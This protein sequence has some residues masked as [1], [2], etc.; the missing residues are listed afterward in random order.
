MISYEEVLKMKA[1]EEA[2][3]LIAR[4]IMEWKKVKYRG[5]FDWQDKD[6]DNVYSVKGWNPSK[7]TE[8]AIEAL[9]TRY[10][11]TIE[12]DHSGNY[13]VKTW[14]NEYAGARAAVAETLALAACRSLLL[15]EA[16][17]E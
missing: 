14:V 6:G 11:Y 10:E 13:T 15:W 12:K 5:D 17:H 9:E 4:R 7:N 16:E 2:D 1:G 3:S 8:K